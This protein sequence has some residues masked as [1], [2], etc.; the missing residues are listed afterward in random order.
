ME[1]LLHVPIPILLPIGTLR[2]FTTHHI[3]PSHSFQLGPKMSG[4]MQL[5]QMN[6]PM[7]VKPADSESR[8]GS[9][10]TVLGDD[11]KL[12][13]GMLSKQQTE[14]EVR[15]LFSPFGTIDEVCFHDLKVKKRIMHSHFE[16]RWESRPG[17]RPLA[18]RA[19]RTMKDENRKA[20]LF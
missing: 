20:T 16:A 5:L 19:F 9:P 14:E 12:F 4:M 17:E 10:K 18:A 7:Q 3:H 13:I 11:R 8:P 15:M 6:R 1:C 2:I